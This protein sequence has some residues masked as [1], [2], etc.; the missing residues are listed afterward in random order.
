MPREPG[1]GWLTRVLRARVRLKPHSA[2]AD[3]QIVLEEQRLERERVL[4]R[5]AHDAQEHPRRCAG[6][7]ST[8]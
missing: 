1:E 5:R 3:L 6:A 8:T 7:G 4:G 2:R